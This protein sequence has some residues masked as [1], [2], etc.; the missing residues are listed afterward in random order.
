M[1]KIAV[2][3]VGSLVGQNILDALEG[4][5]DG[6]E[7]VGINSTAEAAGNFR[8][9][10]AYLAPPAAQA[11]AYLDRLGSILRDEAPGLVLPGRDD[12]VLALALLK[13]NDTRLRGAITVG[14]AHL[15][16]ILGDKWDSQAFAQ[17][18]GLPYVDSV[19][20]DDPAAV[21]RL[22]ARFGYPLLAKPRDGNGSRGARIV[23]DDAQRAALAA[24]PGYLFQPYLEPEPELAAWRELTREG[25][26]LFHAPTLRQIGCQAIIGADG[27]LRGLL[28][29]VVELVMGRLER[30]FCLDDAEVADVALRYA[31]AFAAAGWTGAL[32]L[33]GRRDDQGRL[34]VYEL[35]GRLTGGTTA[36]LHLGFDELAMLAEAFAGHRLPGRPSVG[37]RGVVTKSLAEFA[38]DPADIARLQADQCWHRPASA[39]DPR[40]RPT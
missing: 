20:A 32:N 39:I 33:Q 23:F 25:T 19:P 12:D 27:R 16:R 21:G 10:R 2:T 18:H 26:P 35:N 30:T 34:R 5:R 6:V 29:T 36:R 40:L 38:V 1:L 14:P 8:C 24:R 22:L 28:C 3:S 9:D 31:E 7:L 17:A 11:P 15:A 4:R 13:E 37:R